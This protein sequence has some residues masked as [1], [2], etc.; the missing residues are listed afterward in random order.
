MFRLFISHNHAQ[1]S[2]VIDAH[3][4]KSASAQPGIKL[5]RLP[6]PFSHK[7]E[8]TPGK[9]HL[10]DNSPVYQLL[11]LFQGRKMADPEGFHDEQASFLCRGE[12]TFPFL[13]IGGKGLLT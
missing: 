12:K 13:Y 11:H 9:S 7:A 5:A 6:C 3:I 1:K 10:A 4:Q 8:I 2:Q